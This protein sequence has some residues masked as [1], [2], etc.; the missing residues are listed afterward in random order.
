MRLAAGHLEPV[1]PAADAPVVEIH[2]LTGRHFWHQTAF[3]AWSLARA[4]GV[5]VAPVLY[6]DGTLSPEDIARVQWAL[7]LTR[8]VGVAE[9]EARVDACL[10]RTRFPHLR[11]RRDI[12]PNLR[13]LL[14]VHAGQR[15]WKLVL[16]SDMLFFRRPDQLL[17]WLAAP[18]R[19]CHM[20]DVETSYGYPIEFLSRQCGRSV[21]ERVNV[22]ATGLRS[23]AIDWDALE[24]WTR[25]QNE[26]HGP[27][28][29]QE[30]ALIAQLMA[31]QECTVLAERDYWVLPP[32]DEIERPQAVLHHYV[33]S[34]K[35]GY[36]W[37]GWRNAIQAGDAAP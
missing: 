29:Y 16:D 22:G 4:S 23:E 13:K 26:T 20:V 10:P 31:G 14:D 36:F 27:S 32:D 24:A 21:A 33:A 3:C 34:S 6:D 1:R 25:E 15:G 9:I 11:A 12:Y 7:P 19:P 28:Y 5:E 37:H 2:F 30:Q 35:P 18:D 17:A 8:A